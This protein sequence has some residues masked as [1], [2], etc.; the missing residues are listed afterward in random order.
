MTYQMEPKIKIG[1]ITYDVVEEPGLLVNEKFAGCIRY[2]DCKIAIDIN[3][4]PQAKR[5]TLWHEIV[6]AILTEA[7]Y[8]K[9]KESMVD[10]LTYGI[11]GV[12]LDNPWLMNIG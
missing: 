7:G 2:I 4:S 9:Q 1:P 8:S 10:A 12:L 5:K 6:H 3:M 11:M